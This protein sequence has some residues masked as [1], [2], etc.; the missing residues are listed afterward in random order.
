MTYHYLDL[1]H[2]C[3]IAVKAAKRAG[4]YIASQSFKDNEVQHKSAGSSFA[5]S[6]FTE[7]DMQSQKIILDILV[8]TC[9][10]YHIGMLAEE[11]AEET[12]R[13]DKELFWAIDP[14]DGSLPFI[15][16][17]SGFAVSI[18][19]V[20]SQGNAVLGVVYDPLLS[21]T[22]HA[23]KGKGA[24][25]NNRPFTS[26]SIDPSVSFLTWHTDRSLL[27]SPAFKEWKAILSKIAIDLGYLGLRIHTSS[28]AV[29]HAIAVVESPNTIYFKPPKKMNGGGSI[30][31]FA[32]TS[33]IGKEA[34]VIVCNFQ[35]KSLE[36]NDPQTQYMNK[37]G[38]IYCR[39][40]KVVDRLLS[41]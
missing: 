38:V 8:P 30:W 11:S 3:A 29:M 27:K 28:G 36:L 10:L 1:E 37:Q 6:V 41:L 16:G 34:G 24:Y 26:S 15:Q 22:Y 12:D 25:R 20:T 14:L 23:I 9:E 31:D 19:L 33:I 18:A 35:R 40:N 5:S 39:E 32:A 2:L 13:L 7:V 21:T 17:T 4:E